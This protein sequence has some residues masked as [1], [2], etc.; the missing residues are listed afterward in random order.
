MDE[1]KYSLVE[2]L[3]ELRQRIIYCL[4]FFA[5][6]AAVAWQWVPAIMT[7]LSTPV[8]KL[9]FLHPVEA[10]STYIKVAFW[11]GFFLSLP[12]IFYHFWKFLSAGLTQ[13][14]RKNII[15]FAPASFILFFLG[16]GFA[17]TLA[18]PLALKFLIG[19]GAGWV[20]PMISLDQ[21][22]SFVGWLLLAFGLAFELPIAILFLVRLK[23][24]T[25][26]SLARY[27]R[28]AVLI[29]IIAAA[30]LTP[31]PDAFT[32]LLLAIPLILLYEASIWLSY[33]V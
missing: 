18:I 24:M 17:L 8:E 31:T 2:H 1:A 25:P 29:I 11:T 27:R 3:A 7:Y 15:I 23:I 30:I 21:Y 19:F 13:S 6:A 22:L 20:E 16:A 4:I 14:E 33:L 10:F 12:V 5:I 9:V 28:H 32:Q 26:R